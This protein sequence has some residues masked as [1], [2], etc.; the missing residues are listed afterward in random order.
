V[1]WLVPKVVDRGG[2]GRHKFLLACRGK[3]PPWANGGGS[4]Y[5]GFSQVKEGKQNEGVL[6][7]EVPQL[8]NHHKRFTILPRVLVQGQLP[9]PGPGTAGPEWAYMG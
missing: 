7:R 1:L 8:G 3:L 9:V 5:P 2:R 6:I 4:F